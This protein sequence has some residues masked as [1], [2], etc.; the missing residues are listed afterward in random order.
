MENHPIPQD[1]TGFKFK[2][3]GSVTIKQFLYLM[4]FGILTTIAFVLNVNIF[5]KVP[6]M[7]F[8][9]G[10]GTSLA[11]LPIDGRPMDT[12]IM[13]FAKTIPSENRYIFVKRGALP[14]A[15]EIFQ[16]P[17]VHK[18]PT[19]SAQSQTQRDENSDKRA[20]L[21]S[22]LRNSPLRPD[23]A[24]MAHL[25]SIKSFFDD[26]KGT[27]FVKPAGQA[28]IQPKPAPRIIEA[29][30][31]VKTPAETIVPLPETPPVVAAPEEK[32][33]VAEVAQ[34]PATTNIKTVDADG[35][36]DVN[37]E[38]LSSQPRSAPNMTPSPTLTGGFPAL[39]DVPNIIMGLV[40]DPR[41][42]TLPNILVEVMDPNGIPVRAFKTN[43]LGQFSSATPLANGT[44]KVSFED[45]QKHHEFQPMDIV[46]DGKIFMP[47]ETMSI[48]SREK[49]RR[50][51]FGGATA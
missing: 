50:E 24:E 45:P 12:M 21:L 3:V 38:S 1:V 8:F 31:P 19:A 11:F 48:D 37:S 27:T 25:R 35:T 42:K 2:L 46:I 10:I 7:L 29:D 23:E 49:L 6:L 22:R 20:M 30:A 47:I 18:T 5:I 34:V 28:T 43:A 51:L 26:S 39:P 40:R 32:N 44:Y 33:E 15:F 36:K 41:G 16:P 14:S 4:G 17:V 13:N 9:A